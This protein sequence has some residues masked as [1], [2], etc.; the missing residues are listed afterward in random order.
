VLTDDLLELQR[1]DTLA[2]QLAHR[3]RNA[4]ER[5]AATAARG[6]VEEHQRR[7]AASV[8]REQELELTI[9]ALER[10]GE[11]LTTQRA[12]LEAQLKTVISPREAEALMHELSTLAERR[13]AL[14]DQELA[15][16]EEQSNL[17]DAIAALD[18]DAPRLEADAAAAATALSV[19]EAEIDG[20]LAEVA[21]ARAELVARLDG[22]TIE[23]YERLRARYGGVAVAK[24][25]GSRCGGCHLDLSTA[26]LNEVRA[27]GA[28]EFAECPNCGRLLVP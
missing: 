16:L 9:D 17:A 13:D 14:D 26:E 4:P 1:L 19:V 5:E 10:D 18:A 6:A 12:R 24:L 21:A 25:E 15:A 28:G 22:A 8:G 2:D 11:Q 27:V 7:R 3:R 20:E 23:R